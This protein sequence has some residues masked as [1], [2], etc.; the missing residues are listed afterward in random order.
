MREFHSQQCVVVGCCHESVWHIPE[1]AC[2]SA[3]RGVLC[4]VSAR[5]QVAERAQEQ[6]QS[7]S[8]RVSRHGQQLQR[9]LR[10]VV[11]PL[12]QWQAVEA[13]GGRC[14]IAGLRL[15]DLS[16]V[17]AVGSTTATGLLRVP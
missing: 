1:A 2:H 4:E 5:I 10:C 7:A 17:K 9:L 16:D 8:Q 15:P 11:S 3:G 13:N 6:L 14:F 12:L